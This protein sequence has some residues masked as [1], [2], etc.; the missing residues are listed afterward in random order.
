M[1]ILQSPCLMC[2]PN[3]AHPDPRDQSG[4]AR[5]GD[6]EAAKTGVV[7]AQPACK[8]ELAA[9]HFGQTQMEKSRSWPLLLTTH[10]G[11]DEAPATLPGR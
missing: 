4:A 3:T 8:T 5:R 1:A 11:A 6:L 2:S 7:A 9:E 10:R